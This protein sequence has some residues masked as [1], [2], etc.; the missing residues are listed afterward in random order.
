MSQ[1]DPIFTGKPAHDGGDVAIALVSIARPTFDTT[2]A[3]AITAKA[4]TQLAGAGFTVTGPQELVSSLA[5]AKAAALNLKDT[6]PDLLLV[7]QSTFAD[8]SIVMELS[9]NVD[10]PLLLWA[11]PEESTGGRLR[12]NSLCGIN[13][14]AHAL[15]RAQHQYDTLYTMPDDSSA[16]DQIKALALAGRVKRRL[17]QARLGRLGEQPAGFETCNFDP[18]ALKH[19]FGLEVVQIDLPDFFRRVKAVDGREVEPVAQEVGRVLGNLAELDQTATRGTLS[20]YVALRQLVQQQHLDGLAVRCWPEFFTE[21]GCAACGAMSLLSHNLTPCSC[22]ADVN[23]AITQLILQ[24]LSGE[25]AF[26]SDLVAVDEKYGG[27]VLWHCG[28]AP[29]SMADPAVKP[30]GTIHSNRNLPLLMEF[31]LKPGRVTIARLSEATGALRLVIGGGDIIQAPASFSGTSGVLRFDRP[32]RQVLDAILSEGLEHHL[33][34]TYG[35]HGPALA[36]L[37]RMVNIPVL[38][39]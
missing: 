12:L 15:T 9:Q 20:T 11:I 34:I 27:L 29:L 33:S 26:G 2:L 25:P 38:R 19:T 14:A 30:R 5:E 23:G 22:E 10:A 24:W 35:D 8:S 32:V 31:T 4:R 6:L 36:A 18:D 37:A 28:L 39:L 3:E 21:L 7:L 1:S 16:L 17:R 13:L